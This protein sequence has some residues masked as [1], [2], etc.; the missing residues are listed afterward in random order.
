MIDFLTTLEQRPDLANALATIASTLIAVI[1][2]AVSLWS[3][4]LQRHHNVL[5]LRPLPWIDVDDY[6]DSLSVTM[7][8]HGP[9]PLIITEIAVTSGAEAKGSIIDWMPDLP[10]GAFWTTFVGSVDQPRSL[11]PAGEL[12][13]LKFDGNHDEDSFVRMRDDCRMRLASLTV[14]VHYTDVYGSRLSPTTRELSW[15]GRER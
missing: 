14:R 4:G 8:N 13:L 2:F 9:G 1:A 15:F 11:P 6:E 5:S 12:C 3:L 10:E 7:K